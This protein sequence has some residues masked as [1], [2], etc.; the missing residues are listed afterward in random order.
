M[1][2]GVTEGM[3]RIMLTVV[4]IPQKERGPVGSVTIELLALIWQ[5]MAVML[6]SRTRQ[7]TGMPDEVPEGKEGKTVVVW[8]E[9]PLT[10]FGI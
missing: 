1:D 7:A 2:S 8:G 10:S 5:G 3:V 6:Q 9:I 4:V